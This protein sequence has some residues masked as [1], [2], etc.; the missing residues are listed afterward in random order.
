[1]R[2]W[3][4]GGEAVLHRHSERSSVT[5]S[6]VVAAAAS[7][8]SSS[9]WRGRKWRERNGNDVT[10]A[11]AAEEGFKNSRGAVALPHIGCGSSPKEE[12]KE[13][14]SLGGR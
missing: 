6:R 14:K 13:R 4:G 7:S 5:L 1:M 11:I 3:E 12:K 2:D 8:S 10:A 9:S